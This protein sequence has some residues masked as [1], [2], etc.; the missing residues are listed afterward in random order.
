LGYWRGLFG[1]LGGI[2]ERAC[3]LANPFNLDAQAARPRDGATSCLGTSRSTSLEITSMPPDGMVSFLADLNWTP[4]DGEASVEHN[5]GPQV[6]G[7]VALSAPCQLSLKCLPRRQPRSYG[8]VLILRPSHAS[9][10]MAKR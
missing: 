4:L 1:K 3:T 7:D 6:L 5:K 9:R 8:L 2:R 10:S